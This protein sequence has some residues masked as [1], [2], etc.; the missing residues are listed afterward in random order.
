VSDLADAAPDPIVRP[1]VCPVC[2]G[3]NGCGITAGASTCWCFTASIP[4]EALARVPEA[5]R[6]RS[7]L[8]AS[9]AGQTVAAAPS[10]LEP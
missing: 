3:P 2:G 8:C 6:D 10:P 7:C 5:A 1:D 9:C 4:A